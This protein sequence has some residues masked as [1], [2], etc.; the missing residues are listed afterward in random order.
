MFDFKA[1]LK[2]GLVDGY[3][4]GSFSM[5]YI[6][7]MTANYI[8]AGML[9]QADAAEIATACAAWDEE[10][11]RLKEKKAQQEVDPGFTQPLDP[12]TDPAT[13]G[14]GES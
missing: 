14:E 7:T 11:K 10:Q 3:K 2:T 5:P 4:Q 6:T 1:W 12:S 9:M 8:V 13:G